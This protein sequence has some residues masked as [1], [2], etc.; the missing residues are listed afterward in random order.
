MTRWIWIVRLIGL[1]MLLGFFILFAHMQRRLMEMQSV[2]K[3]P[4]ATGTR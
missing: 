2:R 3:P 4:A 1:L